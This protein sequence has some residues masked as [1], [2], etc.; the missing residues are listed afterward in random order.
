MASVPS[1]EI[2]SKAVEQSLSTNTI[3]QLDQTNTKVED[4]R[5]SSHL[6]DSI[7]QQNHLFINR[8]LLRPS[9]V[10]D[11]LP[12][13]EQE[14]HELA[15]ILAPALNYETPSNVIIYGKTGTGKTASVKYVCGELQTQGKAMGKQIHFLYVNAQMTD[16]LYKILQFVGQQLINNLLDVIPLNGLSIDALFAKITQRLDTQKQVIVIVLDESDKIKI[17]DE[18]L[19]TL[20]RINEQL[21]LA[22]VSLICISNDLKFTEHLDAR[23]KSSFGQENMVFSPYDAEQLQ[24]ILRE[25][26]RVALKLDTIDDEVIPLCSAL[27][28]REHGDARKAL[29]LLR[30][31]AEV[32][33]RNSEPKITRKHVRLAEKKI[34]CDCMAEVVRSL[35]LHSKMV[36]IAILK[37]KKNHRDAGISQVMTTGEVYDYYRNQ[38]EKAEYDALSQRRIADFISELDMLGVITA[39]VISKG[40]QGRTKEISLSASITQIVEI[41]QEDE[42][43]RELLHYNLKNQTRLNL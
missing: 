36:L 14:I 34:E 12:H 13:R 4:K 31:S 7:L 19:Y 33:E 25:R 35:P 39:R 17:N 16:T 38:C 2:I 21:R 32:A 20:T 28:A 37:T 1:I 15:Q 6:F 3:V 5:L 24:D 27:A 18:A 9:F 40:R 10:P 42:T 30:V 23:V 41:L 26:A 22:R 8:E 11:V 43:L 29:D